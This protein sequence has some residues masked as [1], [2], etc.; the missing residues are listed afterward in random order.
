MRL[1]EKWILGPRLT[2]LLL[3]KLLGAQS[4]EH[5]KYLIRDQ[6][7]HCPW[8]HLL[9]LLWWFENDELSYELKTSAHNVRPQWLCGKW[10]SDSLFWSD[11]DTPPAPIMW[12]CAAN[13]N[14]LDQTS[15]VKRSI[16][17]TIGFPNHGESQT[18]PHVPYDFYVSNP[19]SRLLTVGS[20]PV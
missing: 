3:E 5:C 19:I 8:L 6:K 7:S 13:T 2:T 1:N 17:S 15:A 16:G 12:R 10:P 20:T 18:N 11:T 14:K 4:T 9:P